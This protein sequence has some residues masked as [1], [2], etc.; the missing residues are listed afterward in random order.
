MF[1]QTN[2]KK[3]YWESLVMT[4]VAFFSCRA[5]VTTHPGSVY[6]VLTLDQQNCNP[7]FRPFSEL[8]DCC[9][10]AAQYSRIM[11]CVVDPCSVGDYPGTVR[12][13]VVMS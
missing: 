4:A 1:K 3:Y 12:V 9:A 5:F 7:T 2:G 13:H 6:S 10:H 11:V 8:R